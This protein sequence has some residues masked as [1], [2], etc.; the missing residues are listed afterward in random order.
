MHGLGSTKETPN[1]T[2]LVETFLRHN[3]IVVNFDATNSVGESEGKYEDATLGKHYEDLV[4]VISWAKKQE[5]YKE[6][7]MLAG[8]SMGGYAV[9]QYA[10]DFPSE[11]KGVFAFAPCISGALSFKAKEKYETESFKNWKSTGWQIRESKSNPGLIKKL[12]WSHM[13]ERL[14]HD[15][16]PNS[17]RLNMP[18]AILVGEKDEQCPLEH[19]EILFNNLNTRKD[20]YTITG[21]PHTFRSENDLNSLKK[22]LDLWLSS[23]E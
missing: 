19:Q 22:H 20:L 14:I 21:A 2:Y 8:H 5:W 15:L 6:P 17:S 1:I 3:Y 11:V 12:P 4:D 23:F 13:E 7:F 9:L 10:E 16:L 18:V